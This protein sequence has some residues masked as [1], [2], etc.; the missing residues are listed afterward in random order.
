MV[1]ATVVLN[2]LPSCAAPALATIVHVLGVAND[3]QDELVI[4]AALRVLLAITAARP[5]HT[6]SVLTQGGAA[7][8]VRKLLVDSVQTAGAET[9]GLA[10]FLTAVLTPDG[11]CLARVAYVPCN[12]RLVG[13][14]FCR[15]NGGLDGCHG[16]A[17]RCQVSLGS[18]LCRQ[19]CPGAA[20][21][22]RRRSSRG[23]VVHEWGTGC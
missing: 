22:C 2:S 5:E 8:L 3:R 10:L 16:C 12:P 20:V 6:V 17:G 9:L 15:D 21:V 18:I 13:V 11:T 1:Y 19:G 23:I 4:R 14:V 7:W